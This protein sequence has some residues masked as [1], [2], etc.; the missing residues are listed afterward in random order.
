MGGPGFSAFV[1]GTPAPGLTPGK[2]EQKMGQHGSST[3]A[4]SFD[5]V[6]VPPGALL[7]NEGDGLR[8]ALAG[9]GSGRIGIAALSIAS[10]R[11]R[12]QWP[13]R[14]CASGDSSAW[15]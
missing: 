15:L 12:W 7:S 9:L 2:R 3:M 8:V 6:A 14:T 10:P 13:C 11:R 5:D 4:M 1:L